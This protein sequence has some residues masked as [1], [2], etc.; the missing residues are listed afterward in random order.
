MRFVARGP[1]LRQYSRMAVNAASHNIRM[2]IYVLSAED[3]AYPCQPAKR[4]DPSQA[5]RRPS[6]RM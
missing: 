5:R 1:L 4:Q 3:N 2:L 6:R